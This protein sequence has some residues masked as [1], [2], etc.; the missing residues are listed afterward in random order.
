MTYALIGFFS[1]AWFGQDTQ[2]NILEVPSPHCVQSSALSYVHVFA[3][4]APYS[5]T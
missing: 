2:G 3:E 5:Q 1:A 4:T